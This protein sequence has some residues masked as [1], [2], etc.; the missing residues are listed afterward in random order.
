MHTT[1]PRPASA[2]RPLPHSIDTHWHRRQQGIVLAVALIFLIIVTLIGLAAVRGTTVQ[3]RMMA[4]F[5][6]RELAFQNAEAGLRAGQALLTAGTVNARNC[7]NTHCDAN[8]FTDSTLD[9]SLIQTAAT[10]KYT[11]GSN[12]PG[13]PQ[14]IIELICT[15]CP[16][17]GGASD[18]QQSAN[19]QSYGTQP[20]SDSRSQFFRI[21]ARS[22]DPT[23][24]EGANRAVVT[25]QALF[26]VPT[27]VNTNPGGIGSIKRLSW[28]ELLT[29]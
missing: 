21:T 12:A 5:Y 11:A 15:S 18:F 8:P 1:Y 26:A 3:K 14:F 2:S 6:D 19:F 13:Q 4:N 9:A 29:Q 28:R 25:L 22:S 24:E 7:L 23:S 27:S 16:S 10:S 17:P 20:F